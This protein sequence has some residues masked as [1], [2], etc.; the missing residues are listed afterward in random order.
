M[1]LRRELYETCI[2][3]P[4]G[5]A[6]DPSQPQNIFSKTIRKMSKALMQA[7]SYN[8]EILILI[9]LKYDFFVSKM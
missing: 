6:Q 7:E 3:V 5:T 1:A 2:I 8:I 4:I 9:K